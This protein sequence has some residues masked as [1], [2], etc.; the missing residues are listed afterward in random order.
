MPG[1][2]STSPGATLRRVPLACRKCAAPP[3]YGYR[4]ACKQ[5]E[6][7]GVQPPVVD[8]ERIPAA[9]SPRRVASR[10]NSINSHLGNGRAVRYGGRMSTYCAT[11]APT[12]HPPGEAHSLPTPAPLVTTFASGPLPVNKASEVSW[13]RLTA[14]SI[15]TSRPLS[16]PASLSATPQLQPAQPLWTRVAKDALGD[17]RRHQATRD[18]TS[19]RRW[20]S[21]CRSNQHCV[22]ACQ[23]AVA[24]LADTAGLEDLR[25]QRLHP[26]VLSK[27]NPNSHPQE[28]YDFCRQK[29]VP[30][31]NDHATQ[32]T[33]P[34]VAPQRT[35][36][37]RP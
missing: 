1:T 26:V 8:G 29:R 37:R 3:R 27:G 22:H 7:Q 17:T 32:F 10:D 5:P 11:A 35:V 14:H 9:R 19:R 20:P 2:D 21:G 33:L 15:R 24:E 31:Q 16:S 34:K 6:G 36:N 18:R 13:R 30:R 4:L 25:L 23:F 12:R 28:T